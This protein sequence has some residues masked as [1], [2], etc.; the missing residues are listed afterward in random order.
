M[1]EIANKYEIPCVDLFPLQPVFTKENMEVERETFWKKL[2]L[3]ENVEG[4]V[5]VSKSKGYPV[6]KLKS[7]WYVNIH[8]SCDQI[9]NGKAYPWKCVIEETLDD[10]YPRLTNDLRERLEKF[11]DAVKKRIQER[12]L[13]C[14]L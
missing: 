13:L 5:L 3:L 6:C 11:N 14:N 9:A 8:R 10:V 7:D 2:Y 4:C 1:C 12:T